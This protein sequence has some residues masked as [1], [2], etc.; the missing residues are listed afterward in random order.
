M[1][2]S[3]LEG[4]AAGAAQVVG[5]LAELAM[6]GRNDE[7]IFVVRNRHQPIHVFDGEPGHADAARDAFV[8]RDELQRAGIPCGVAQT[9]EDLVNDPQIQHNRTLREA[10]YPDLG[11]VR[12]ARAAALFPA[13]PEQALPLAPHLGENTNDVLSALGRTEAQIAAA[14]KSHA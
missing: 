4:E 13:V 12:S 2:S 3:D 7:T 14:E 5:I 8:V 10:V 9:G 1:C 11:R 6:R